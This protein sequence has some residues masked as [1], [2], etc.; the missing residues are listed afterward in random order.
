MSLIKTFN[1]PYS[2]FNPIFGLGGHPTTCALYVRLQL[3][4]RSKPNTKTKGKPKFWCDFLR[5]NTGLLVA[6]ADPPLPP[7]I[8]KHRKSHFFE[9]WRR[10]ANRQYKTPL[11]YKDAPVCVYFSTF[12]I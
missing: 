8:S 6:I 5:G 2:A 10:F 1:I 3:A 7:I 11:K 4:M 9:F 12:V